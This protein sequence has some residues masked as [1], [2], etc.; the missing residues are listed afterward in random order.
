[1]RKTPQTL[2]QET[3][4]ARQY[5][6]THFPSEFLHAP[7]IDWDNVESTLIRYLYREARET[8]WFHHLAFCTA[9]LA[10]HTKLD[11]HSVRSYCY[12]LQARFRTLF[13]RYDISTFDQWSPSEHILRYLHDTELPDSLVVR[14]DF[15]CLY[16]ASSVHASAY[17]RTLPTPLRSVYQ[18]WVFPILPSDL[19]RTVSQHELLHEEQRQRRKAETDALAP[20]FS[21]IRGEAH[22]RWNQLKRLRDTF[23]E[24]I[25]LV[26]SGQ[27]VLPLTFSYREPH[28]GQQLTFRL[29]DRYSFFTSHAHQ[30][31]GHAV[32]LSY[33]RKE[34]SFASENNHFFL[35]FLHTDSERDGTR[36]ENT[37]LW[38]GDLLQYKLLGGQSLYGSAE[39]IQRKQHYLRS[40]GYGEEGGME[41]SRPFHARTPGVLA[42]SESQ[43]HYLQHAQKLA[44]G[45]LFL[46]DPLFVGA[47]FGLAALDLFT[48]TGA[49]HNEVLQIS[50][51]SE[52]LY[53][54]VVEGIH[55]YLLR[56]IPK[57]SDKPA[58]Y[59]VGTE[60]LSNLEKVGDVLQEHYHLQLGESIPV[61]PFHPTHTRA[62]RFTQT[63]PYIFQYAGQHFSHHTLT[64]CIRFLC[65][66]LVFQTAEGRAVTLKAHSLRH[67]FATHI[68][69]VEAVPLDIIAVMLHQKNVRVTAYY[70]APPWQQVLATAN[71]LL[72]KFAT[73]L[74]PVE[75]AFA[76]APAEL[77]QQLEEA[78]AQVGSLNKI[79]GGNCTCHTICPISFACTGCVYNVPDPDR[80]EE[81]VEQ[82]QWAFIRLDQ[83]KKRG[84]G[85]EIVK[86][87]ALIQRCHVTRQ[88]MQLIRIYRKDES[89]VPIITL[90]RNEQ[91][92]A[93]VT[94]TLP[95]ETSAD[96]HIGQGCS[97]STRQRK[98]NGHD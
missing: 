65:H 29:W 79:P 28:L 55:R 95:G 74:G 35:E 15:L 66:G 59:I 40:W 89:D 32:H 63:R 78:K 5:F 11:P 97:R 98:T 71:S 84:Q 44:K 33:A 50:L 64:A 47:T 3:E 10:S 17:L 43:G 19:Y 22:L 77:Q 36:E 80:E 37:L 61:V 90:E 18:R 75:E 9:I 27:E 60:T 57:G 31:R 49:R 24:S 81:I 92:E 87:Q 76:R 23:R 51:D 4:V 7:L 62:H 26:Q 14:Q 82:E 86:M 16:N 38:F 68:H 53:T 54:V 6:Q 12:C 56:L 69:Q 41:E 58:D 91:A 1:M 73:H 52:C 72:D 13:S 34:N 39:E 85:P 8:P 42:V 94:Q 93:L 2:R 70:A 30:Y 48:T 83:V 20:H 67:V 45:F 21:Q 46:V 25:A 96:G 88:E